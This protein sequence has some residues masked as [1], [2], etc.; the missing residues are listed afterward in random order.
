[1]ASGQD[2]RI[3]DVPFSS[4]PDTNSTVFINDNGKLRQTDLTT[5][6]KYSELY[7]AIIEAHENGLLSLEETKAQLEQALIDLANE[8]FELL[9]TDHSENLAELT[10]L[11]ESS[12][13]GI[14]QLVTEGHAKLEKDVAAVDDLRTKVDECFQSVSDG[15]ATLASA[16]T[17]KKVPTDADATFAEMAA[18]IESITLGSGN[19]TAA[20][21]LVGKTF[22]NDDGVEY[23]GTMADNGAV[24]QALNCGGSYT[25]PAG[26][27]NGS[28]K[29]T[30]NTLAS[31]TAGT[32]TA[33]EILNSKTAWVGGSKLTGTMTDRGAVQVAL[34]RNDL[35]DCMNNG[36]EKKIFI[37]AGYHNGSGYVSL[38]VAEAQHIRD[39]YYNAGVAAGGGIKEFERKTA[40]ASASD[41]STATASCTKYCSAGTWIVGVTAKGDSPTNMKTS[42]SPVTETYAAVEGKYAGAGFYRVELSSPANITAS[43]L[44]G[45]N[46]DF[47]SYTTAT[48]VFIKIK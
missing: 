33:A 21:V 42:C 31:Q 26:Y 43:G 32:A 3:T 48:A 47:G 45:S 10:A 7:T 39:T 29:V 41:W 13:Q 22:T 40:Y 6:A 12:V 17:D 9:N 1:M 34:N 28:G 19:A 15:K 8:K 11:Y 23:T 5:I 25:I 2:I 16:I 30:A 4:V 37:P 38:P 46:S 44:A 20:D 24:T 18:N 27:H 36:N 35:W 14:N